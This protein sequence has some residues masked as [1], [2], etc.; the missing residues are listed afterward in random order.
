[1]SEPRK[2]VSG[3]DTLDWNP[4]VLTVSRS[5][6]TRFWLSCQIRIN[7]YSGVSLH[8]YLAPFPLWDRHA[9]FNLFIN[10]RPPIEHAPSFFWRGTPSACLL[11]G[12]LR[13]PPFTEMKICVTDFW[14]NLKSPDFNQ[15]FCPMEAQINWN[16]ENQVLANVRTAEISFWQRHP[17]LKSGCFDG[18]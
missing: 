16:R 3:N 12:I 10:L 11:H 6:Q 15:G 17:W 9:V 14:G 1:M 18:E 4:D 2:S 8:T 7:T 5:N 13:E